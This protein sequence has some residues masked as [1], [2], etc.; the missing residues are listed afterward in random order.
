MSRCGCRG[1]S[2]PPPG[3]EATEC[4]SKSGTPPT[5][6]VPG[7]GIEAAAWLASSVALALMPKCPACLAAYVA[8][9]TGIGLTIPTAANLRLALMAMCVVSLLSL[10][11]IRI[12]AVIR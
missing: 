5:S 2:T 3:D 9:G 7:L 11:A 8:I 1:T 4:G 12:R 10:A 6:T